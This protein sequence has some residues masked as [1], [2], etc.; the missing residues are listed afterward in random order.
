MDIKTFKKIVS[1][2]LC[3][4]KIIKEGSYYY[5][6]KSDLVIVMGLQK[7]NYSKGYYI[8]IG[9]VINQLNTSNK[10]LRDVDGHVR[11]RFTVVQHGKKTDFFN[12]EDFAENDRDKLNAQLE[13]NFKEYVDQVTSVDKLKRL[14]HDNPVMLYLTTLAAKQTL[15]FE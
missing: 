15:G 11:T 2:F 10:K 8:N 4:K 5:S 3:S 7:S 6:Y 13:E 12:L 14:L 9:Y 1:D